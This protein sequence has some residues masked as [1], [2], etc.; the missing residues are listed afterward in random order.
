MVHLAKSFFYFIIVYTSYKITLKVKSETSKW[1]LYN[2]VVCFAVY[3][4]SNLV[5]WYPWSVNETLGQILMLTM[6]P[7]LWGFAS[8]SCIIRYPKPGIINGVLLNTL[9]FVVEAIASDLIF[10]VVIRNSRDKLMHVTTLYAW[11]FVMFFPFIIFFVFRKL[12]I[13]N[14]KQLAISD[15][16]KPLSIGLISFVVI[17]MILLFNIKFD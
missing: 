17:T 11:G 10:F 6:N 1:I 9:I 14:K 8:Y 15:F 5:L 2:I 7:L 13:R 3:W 4:L 16:W 12:I